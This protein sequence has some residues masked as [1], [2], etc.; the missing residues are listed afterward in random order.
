MRDFL[1]WDLDAKFQ[2]SELKRSRVISERSLVSTGSFAGKTRTAYCENP[3]HLR[4][5]FPKE[6]DVDRSVNSAFFYVKD[7]T[8]Q[9]FW[10]SGSASG[11]EKSTSK[12]RDKNRFEK[13]LLLCNLTRTKVLANPGLAKSGFEQLGPDI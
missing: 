2:R 3:C 7:E 9:R 12:L 5:P 11:K 4:V 8:V 13:S 6:Y 1:K 10:I